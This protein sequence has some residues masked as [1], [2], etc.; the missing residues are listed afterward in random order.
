MPFWTHVVI[1]LA[2]NNSTDSV[3]LYNDFHVSPGAT[4][5]RSIVDVAVS[6][7]RVFNIG[8]GQP[9]IYPVHWAIGDA[10]S[11]VTP[12]LSDDPSTGVWEGIPLIAHGQVAISYH[13]LVRWNDYQADTTNPPFPAHG[14]ITGSPAQE[15]AMYLS[16]KD[17]VDS[18][19]QRTFPGVVP[20]LC[21]TI[22]QGTSSFP[23]DDQAPLTVFSIR[24]LWS[25]GSL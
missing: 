18:Q 3:R 1:T 21:I 13:P 14:S 25:N 7:I 23:F 20:E 2:S 19:A 12:H 16:G 10:N 24:H 8:T 22:Q 5:L 4:L 9:P 15:V 6:D 11:D 17:H